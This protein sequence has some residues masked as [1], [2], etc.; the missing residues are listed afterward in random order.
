M[1]LEKFMAKLNKAFPYRGPCAICGYW[2]A[3]HRLFDTIHGR[4]QAGESVASLCED[5]ALTR[6]KIKLIEQYEKV[7]VQK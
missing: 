7:E 6:S 1:T 2:D 4:R 5:Y 3:R